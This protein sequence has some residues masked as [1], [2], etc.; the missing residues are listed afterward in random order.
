[1]PADPRLAALPALRKRAE[2]EAKALC[3]V[4][5]DTF[6]L[7]MGADM[8]AMYERG[9]DGMHEDE[10]DALTAANLALLCDPSR[11]ASRD[12]VARL[13]AEALGMEC[14]ATAPELR[15]FQFYSDGEPNH[16]WLLVVT[17]H[18]AR[19]GYRWWSFHSE[20]EDPDGAEGWTLVPGISAVA[21]PA[22]ALTLIAISTLTTTD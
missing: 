17:A 9:W 19:S 6:A 5:A 22:E 18:P 21:D 3:E 11:P 8:P 10:R 1:M 13:V 12:A 20:G 4:C 16:S 15:P 7:H 2:E 14:G